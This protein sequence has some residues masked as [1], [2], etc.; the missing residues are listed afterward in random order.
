MQQLADN[1]QLQTLVETYLKDIKELIILPHLIWHQIPF[2][3]LPLTVPI[4]SQTPENKPS[5]MM[6]QAIELFTRL[7]KKKTTTNVSMP[8]E[9]EIISTQYL[10]DKFPIRY[11]P[12]SQ[13]L[14]YCQ[15][16]PPLDKINYGTVE[17]PNGN[18]PS[19]EFECEKIAN[20]HQI[21]DNQRLK[22]RE[23]ATVKNYRQLAK[24]VQ[25]LHS[26]HH[27]SSCLD[28]PLESILILADGQIT[29]GQ[30]MSPGFRLPHLSG[31]FLS[32]CETNLGVASISDDILSLSTGFLCAGAR[33]VVS[34]LW[35]V[36]DLATALFS[37]FY[38]QNRQQG[39]NRPEALK[40]AQITLRNLPG[41][42]L[43]NDYIS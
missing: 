34:T 42:T 14:Q 40:K 30:I 39:L 32:C 36:D 8:S 31:V 33:N 18:L 15:Q 22:G 12:S 37:I 17:N 19:V 28:S 21:P 13:I 11:I 26:S 7:E 9:S 16:R 23:Q 1:L 25:V 6:R 20:L 43:E 38:Y 10:G 41:T 2:A 3:A 24:K 5:G 4:N 27:A 29:L 35:S